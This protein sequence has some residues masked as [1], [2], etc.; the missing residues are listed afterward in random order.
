MT[1]AQIIERVS[2]QVTTLTKRQ[3]E[4]VVNTIFNSIRNSLQKGDKTEIRGFG[5]F[6]LRARRMK[7]G[8]NPKTGATVA[9][10]AK[11]VPFFKA[12]KELKE[13]LNR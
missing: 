5:S 12:G 4:I 1:K 10:P 8:R 2:E 11:R 3:A 9:V 13:L 7:E 6:R